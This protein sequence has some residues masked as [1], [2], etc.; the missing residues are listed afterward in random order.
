MLVTKP[1]CAGSKSVGGF[2]VILRRYVSVGAGLGPPRQSPA[3]LQVHLGPGVQGRG[4]GGVPLGG[5]LHGVPPQLEVDPGRA[6]GLLQEIMLG[7][8]RGTSA[9]RGALGFIASEVRV[10]L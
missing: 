6:G 10:R 8:V 5:V 7:T 2:S 3:V 9:S 1:F 4:G